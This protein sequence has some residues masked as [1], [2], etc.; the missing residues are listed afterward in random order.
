MECPVCHN[1]AP[2][3]A[4]VCPTCGTMLQSPIDTSLTSSGGASFDLLSTDAMG[5][6]VPLTGMQKARLLFD[7]VPLV[8]F[9]GLLV[10]YATSLNNLFRSSNNNLLFLAF[11]AF[12]LL[13]L[14]YQAIQRL[15]DF[16]SGVAAV[17]VDVLQR[18]WRTGGRSRVF[19][20][21]FEQLGKLRLVS[22]AHF[23]SQNGARYRV[24]YSPVSKIVWSLDPIL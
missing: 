19:Y 18:S 2:F 10:Y 3:G 20:G 4:K 14:G 8:F 7:C 5:E 13:V 16:F 23:G 22:S 6:T 11:G 9:G 12:L 1:N 17:R 21:N 15:R 24:V